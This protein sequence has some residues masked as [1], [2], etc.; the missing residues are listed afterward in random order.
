MTS[1]SPAVPVDTSL[2]P[3]TPPATPGV[4]TWSRLLARTFDMLLETFFVF[5]VVAFCILFFRPDFMD[6]LNEAYNVFV[7]NLV[8]QPVVC[9]LDAVI[10]HL[11]GNTPGKALMGFNVSKADGSHLSFKA[12]FLRNFMVWTTGNAYGL[13]VYCLIANLTQFYS[14]KR[15]GCTTYDKA[16]GYSF[17]G[18]PPSRRRSIFI[19]VLIIIIAISSDFRSSTSVDDD[20]EVDEETVTVL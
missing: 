10:Y 11:F 8:L 1:E 7:L 19:L 15:E 17:N 18:N 14:L 13:P 2:H 5:F 6:W 16:E 4:P 9:V 12:Y 20:T 3:P